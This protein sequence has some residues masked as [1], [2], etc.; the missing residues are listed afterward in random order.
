MEELAASYIAAIQTVQ[1]QGPYL[2]GGWC[3]GGIIAFEMAQQL[4]RQGYEVGLLALLDS[5]LPSSQTRANAMQEEVDLRENIVGR[6][7]V[8]F[9]GIP[10]PDD[11]DQRVPGEQVNYATEQAKKMH[12]LPVDASSEL[13]LRVYR[14]SRLNKHITALYVPQSYQNQINYFI[15]AA[16]IEHTES[17]DK[18]EDLT[19]IAM[20]QDHLRCWQELAKGGIEFHLIPGKHGEMVDEPNVQVL[21][22]ELQRCIDRIC[23]RL[24]DGKVRK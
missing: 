14:A 5:F 12:L 6:E 9:L 15:A 13:A 20:Q 23:D 19:A 4:Q 17:L 16:S 22:K 8:N 10:V 18:G 11:F 3:I 7:L 1:P 21:A 24:V 2:L